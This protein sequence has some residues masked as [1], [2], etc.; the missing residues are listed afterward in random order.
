[1]VRPAR[2]LAAGLRALDLPVESHTNMVFVR[3]P[4]EQ[5]GRL[6]E[7]LKSQ[8]IAVLPGPRMRLVT[9]LDMDTA[10]IDRAVSSFTDYFRKIG[11]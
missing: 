3:I 1:M 5:V 10:G 2:R 8:A 4:P 6:A 7:H 11:V 9:H